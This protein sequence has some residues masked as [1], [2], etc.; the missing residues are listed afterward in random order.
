VVVRLAATTC[1]A[2]ALL[3]PA[4]AALG[5]QSAA[6]RGRS[7][8]GELERIRREREQLRERMT[9]LQ[10]TV[11]ELSEEVALLDRQADA[12][13]R[14]VRTLDTQLAYIAQEVEQASANL[15]S[16]ERELGEKRRVLRRRLVD[17]YKRGPLY[18]AEVLLSAESFGALV[19]R[20]KYL[21]LLTLR[22]QSL[23]R[24]VEQLRNQTEKQR[25][26]L[27][28]LQSDVEATRAERAI[29]ESRLRMLEAAR[30]QSLAQAKRSAART[31][32]RLREIDRAE[33]RLASV[34]ARAE[35][36][37]RREER[38]PNAAAP[39]ASTLRTAELGRLAWPVEGTVL[40]RFGRVVHPNQ[41]TT[42]W[43]GIGIGA[44]V[45]TPVKSISG[46]TVAVAEAIGTYGLTVIVQHGGGDYSVYGSLSRADVSK[47]AT[48]QKGQVLGLVGAA[49][50]DMGPHLHFEIRRSRGVAVDPLE[51]LRGE[52]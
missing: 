33:A 2:L 12:T 5:A 51:W 32:R 37:R 47:G 46:G 17:V 20:Y 10:G 31:A 13:A 28:R 19:A 44:P 43:N 25:Q 16:A 4:P 38:R 14:V 49:D 29:E 34:I 6:A 50:P 42:R 48:V 7:Q 30:G 18:S 8:R 40:Y 41:T 1:V 15:G 35:T 52:R 27:V 21:H 22:D 11:H 24:R 23:V 39:A 9:E 26:L 36:A 45:G 3:F